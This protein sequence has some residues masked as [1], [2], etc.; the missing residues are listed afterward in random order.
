MSKTMQRANHSGGNSGNPHTKHGPKKPGLLSSKGMGK[1]WDRN[2]QLGTMA[3]LNKEIPSGPHHICGFVRFQCALQNILG[4]LSIGPCLL[5]IHKMPSR[6]VV[7]RQ[8][9]DFPIHHRPHY[10][11]ILYPDSL[12][13]PTS[14]AGFEFAS[15]VRQ[16]KTSVSRQAKFHSAQ[17]TKDCP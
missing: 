10:S 8:G 12:Q 11:L 14:L 7:Y 5:T 13:E 9:T 3:R 15:T 6:A 2:E 4:H 17:D 16:N 1:S